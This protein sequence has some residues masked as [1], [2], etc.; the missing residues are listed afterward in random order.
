MCQALNVPNT[1]HITP[2]SSVSG[3]AANIDI[4][5]LIESPYV[6]HQTLSVPLPPAADDA[7]SPEDIIAAKTFTHDKKV[8]QL[9]RYKHLIDPD[10]G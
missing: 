1:P 4:N 9:Q 6:S 3:P 10:V 2:E 7:L 8:R 5:P